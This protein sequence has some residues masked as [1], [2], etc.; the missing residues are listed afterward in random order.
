MRVYFDAVLKAAD[1]L[2]PEC[3]EMDL[4]ADNAA[5]AIRA[6]ANLLGKN[7]AAPDIACLC[8]EVLAR[9]EIN[10]T[11]L[12]S[13]VA[14]PH[15]R[16]DCVSEIVVAAGRSREG[17]LFEKTG[18]RVHFIFVIGTPKNQV[19]EYLALLGNLARAVKRPETRQKLMT[20]GDSR[21]F[22][23]CLET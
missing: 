19:R 9:E 16:T 7:P 21:D 5:D 8:K 17:I 11:A 12:G 13:E 18:E 22:V 15:A 1:L 23:S 2:K 20:A 4:R 3:V 14:F 10:P 6:V